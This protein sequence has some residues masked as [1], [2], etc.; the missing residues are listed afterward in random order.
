M[1]WIDETGEQAQYFR[2]RPE[3]ATPGSLRLHVGRH[4]IIGDYGPCYYITNDKGEI[5][6]AERNC[7]I[8]FRV[9]ERVLKRGRRALRRMEQAGSEH[10]VEE[11]VID[12]DRYVAHLEARCGL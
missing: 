1:G 9:H 3:A 2:P 4:K 5:V 11:V 10:A 8:K 7:L 12:R 6:A